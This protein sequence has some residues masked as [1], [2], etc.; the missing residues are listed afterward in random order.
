MSLPTTDA[1]DDPHIVGIMIGLLTRAGGEH[2]SVRLAAF[3]ALCSVARN[4]AGQIRSR[5]SAVDSALRTALKDGNEGIRA[6]SMKVLEQY[7][8]SCATSEDP[9]QQ[10]YACLT[11]ALGIS[12]DED[13]AA[14]AAAC[15]TLGVKERNH[16]HNSRP[17]TAALQDMFFLIDVA[18]IVPKH[19]L[20]PALNVRTRASWALANVCDALVSI[21]E[22]HSEEESV[23]LEDAGVT[24]EVLIALIR[25]GLAS[26]KDNDKCRSNGVRALGNIVRICPRPVLL[27]EA[28]R[29][30]KEIV[31]AVIKNVE[32][33]GVKARWNACYAITNMLRTP[34]FPMGRSTWTAPLLTSLCTAVSCR[35]FKVR[36][37]AAGALAAPTAREMYG[38]R[39]NLRAVVRGVVDAFESIDEMGDVGFGEYKYREQLVLQ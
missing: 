11:F 20:D 9:D 16:S 27:R 13:P 4:A 22:S 38:T 19:V 18:A 21:R 39:E 6:A 24:D 23:S 3:D 5:W 8:H 10:R 14:K 26:A 30:V 31:G 28:E 1:S 35:N 32:N 29:F 17:L 12:N 7:A 33:G 34:F 2:L 36:I 37:A 25:A 15:R